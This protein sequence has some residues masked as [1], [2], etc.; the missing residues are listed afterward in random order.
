MANIKITED[1]LFE[2]TE[3]VKIKMEL[4]IDLVPLFEKLLKHQKPVNVSELNLDYEIPMY[5]PK[6]IKGR[7]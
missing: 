7:N 3:M 1:E 5:K 4:D 6:R 2:L